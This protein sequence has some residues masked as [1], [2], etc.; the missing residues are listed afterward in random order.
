MLKRGSL[1]EE[2]PQPRH[3]PV[4]IGRTAEIGGRLRGGNPRRDA[5]ADLHVVVEPAMEHAVEHSHAE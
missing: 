2:R 3:E 1:V 5:G 4:E